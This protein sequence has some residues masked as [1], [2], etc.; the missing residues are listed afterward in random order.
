MK[1]LLLTASALLALALPSTA[2]A[3]QSGSQL[4][5][6]ASFDAKNVRGD[7][8]TDRSRRYT[9][10]L[11]IRCRGLLS[12]V[13]VSYDFRLPDSQTGTVHANVSSDKPV[14]TVVRALD[15]HRYRVTLAV[16]GSRTVDIRAISLTYYT[17]R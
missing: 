4:R 9:R 13:V 3:L 1:R 8:S 2:W 12:S 11:W 16:V 10:D 15:D 14:F 17:S 5:L 7:C 6:A